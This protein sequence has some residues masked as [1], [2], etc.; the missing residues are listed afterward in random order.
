MVEVGL[1][2]VGVSGREKRG[3]GRVS[4]SFIALGI[5]GQRQGEVMGSSPISLAA[6][7]HRRQ[8]AIGDEV[9]SVGLSARAH[10]S[11]EREV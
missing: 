1:A 8:S 9:V 5:E 4:Y 6:I 7:R 3:L 11:V 2:D 10:P